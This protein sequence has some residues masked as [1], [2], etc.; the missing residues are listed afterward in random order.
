MKLYKN[1]IEKDIRNPEVIDRLK[2]EG[3]SEDGEKANTSS[4]D[5]KSE[6]KAKLDKL[7]VKYHHAAGM[8]KLKA[9]LAEAEKAD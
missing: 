3:W 8:D 6:I 1:D 4:D 2:R 7:G 9:L 5:A